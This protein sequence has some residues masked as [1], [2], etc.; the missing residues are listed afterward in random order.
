V[1]F[2][3]LVFVAGA[4]VDKRLHVDFV[5]GGEHRCVLFGRQ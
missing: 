1:G 3:E 5:E 4:E 2:F